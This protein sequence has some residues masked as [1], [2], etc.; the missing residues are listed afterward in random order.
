[1]TDAYLMEADCIHGIVWFE[2]DECSNGI[3]EFKPSPWEQE[4][5][6]SQDDWFDAQIG[7]FEDSPE[8]KE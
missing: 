6:E 1:M 4:Y 7:A 8:A 3:H 5:I 2:C